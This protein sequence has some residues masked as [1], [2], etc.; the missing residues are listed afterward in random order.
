[1]CRSI[2][3]LYNVEPPA[4]EEEIRDAARQFVRKVSGYRTPSKTNEAAF[5]AAITEIGT[6][7]ERLLAGLQTTALPRDREREE[8]KARDLSRRRFAG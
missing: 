4:S 1:M 6:T 5:D 3:T 7:V 2:R 8:Q